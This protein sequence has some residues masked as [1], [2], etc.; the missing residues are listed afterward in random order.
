MDIHNRW[1]EVG[2]EGGAADASHMNSCI[3][4]DVQILFD[5]IHI[6]SSLENSKVTQIVSNGMFSDITLFML[7]HAGLPYCCLI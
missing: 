4:P 7:F 5:L 3:W 6:L 1:E 2:V